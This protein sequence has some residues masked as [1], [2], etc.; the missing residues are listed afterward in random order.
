[1]GKVSF[2]ENPIPNPDFCK[3]CKKKL[4]LVAINTS[5]NGEKS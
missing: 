5:L 4:H 3:K 1:M 2:A